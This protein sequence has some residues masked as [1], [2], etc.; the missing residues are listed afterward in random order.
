MPGDPVVARESL[1]GTAVPVQNFEHPLEGRA[2]VCDNAPT[3][4]RDGVTPVVRRFVE[5]SMIR[6][7]T[8]APALA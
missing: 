6:T 1:A 8:H 5:P 2:L 4:G 7:A 3:L